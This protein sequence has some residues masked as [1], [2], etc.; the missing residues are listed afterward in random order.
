VATT[1]S[2][3]GRQQRCLSASLSESSGFWNRD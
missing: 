2:A 1:E 3:T